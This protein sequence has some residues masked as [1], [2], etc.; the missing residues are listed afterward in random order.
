MSRGRRAPAL[1]QA[2]RNDAARRVL[3]GVTTIEA[4]CGELDVTAQTVKAWINRLARVEKHERLDRLKDAM[5]KLYWLDEDSF[6]GF[7]ERVEVLS[8][9][10]EQLNDARR[11]QRARLHDER[12]RL[13]RLHAERACAESGMN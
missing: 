2:Q 4:V 1:T 5:R 11:E 6:E 7:L 8:V 3:G 12:R 10:A 9:E 13:E